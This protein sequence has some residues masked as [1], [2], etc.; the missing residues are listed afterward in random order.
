MRAAGCRPWARRRSMGRPSGLPRTSEFRTIRFFWPPICVFPRVCSF[1]QD[2]REANMPVSLVCMV[3]LAM[4]RSG[5]TG[6]GLIANLTAALA[7]EDLTVRYSAVVA[8][9]AYGVELKETT[10]RLALLVTGEIASLRGVTTDVLRTI[11]AT[12]GKQ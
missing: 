6:H 1:T 9:T 11:A 3:V 4:D 5:L 10:A 7:D 2:A 12:F 8:L